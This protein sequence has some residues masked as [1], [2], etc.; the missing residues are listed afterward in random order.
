M[1]SS[2]WDSALGKWNTGLWE[3]PIPNPSLK[4]TIRALSFRKRSMFLSDSPAQ[5]AIIKFM[6]K[7]HN[8]WMRL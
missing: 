6:V 5:S 7:R 2:T 3:G 4:D 1:L 8:H